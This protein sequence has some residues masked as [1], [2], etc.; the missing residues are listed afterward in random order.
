MSDIVVST[1][2]QMYD[3]MMLMDKKLDA[4]LI[5]QANHAGLITDHETRIRTVEAQ[6]KLDTRLCELTKDVIDLTKQMR[7]LQKLVWSIPSVATVIALVA[8]GLTFFRSVS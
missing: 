3:L 4:V 7:D 2:Q 5:V 6:E 8:V 1:P